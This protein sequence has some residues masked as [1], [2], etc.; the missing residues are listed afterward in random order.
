MIEFAK[1]FFEFLVQFQKPALNR[2]KGLVHC[3]ISKQNVFWNDRKLVVIDLGLAREK[4][5]LM[6]PIV[7]KINIRA[8]EI[9]LNQLSENNHGD[10]EAPRYSESIDIWSVGVLIHLFITEK[11]FVFDGPNQ[12]PY[13]HNELSI[14]VQRIGMPQTSYL[15]KMVAKDK[16][17]EKTEENTY[18]LKSEIRKIPI[19]TSLEK[20]HQECPQSSPQILDLIKKILVW[21]PAQRITPQEALKHQLFL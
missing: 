11:A 2:E 9:F 20:T 4:G 3:D 12:L 14:L 17:F 19:R 18:V 13:G 21:D 1:Q 15:E 7:Q 8:P 5:A 16:F 10:K 6:D